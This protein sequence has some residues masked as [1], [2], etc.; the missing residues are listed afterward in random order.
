MLFT[1]SLY[2]SKNPTLYYSHVFGGLFF[3]SGVTIDY[4][5]F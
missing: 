3:A 2:S 1:A 4:V 5:T